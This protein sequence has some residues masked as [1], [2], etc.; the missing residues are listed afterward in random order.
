MLVYLFKYRKWEKW[1]Q[2]FGKKLTIFGMNKIIKKKMHISYYRNLNNSIL[3]I[4]SC[5]TSLQLRINYWILG[6]YSKYN[7]I[8]MKGFHSLNTPS[9]WSLNLLNPQ[10]LFFCTGTGL[11][12]SSPEV[13]ELSASDDGS[14]GSL[15][16]RRRALP[17]DIWGNSAQDSAKTW[18]Q[19]QRDCRLR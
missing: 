11:C 7:E 13:R 3:H 4:F 17:E 14:E 16:S 1:K 2:L 15:A 9:S 6:V 10:C 5:Q 19:I 18:T 12:T 8:C